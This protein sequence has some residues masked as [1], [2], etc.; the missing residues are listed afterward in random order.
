TCRAGPP[1][2][3]RADRG[4]ARGAACSRLRR[5]AP[6]ARRAWSDRD[7]R[8]ATARRLRGRADGATCSRD[9]TS[10][11]LSDLGLALLLLHLRDEAVEP[12]ARHDL[13][14]HRSI[15]VDEPDAVGVDVP[16]LELAGFGV[17]YVVDLDLV[18]VAVA[19]RVDLRRDGRVAVLA[20]GL[21]GVV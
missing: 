9:I 1:C 20:G 2:R 13:V 18:R 7:L 8:R 21:A 10:V 12:V 3:T 14:E 15:V 17:Q 19:L 5:A 16:R 4:T 11:V 6:S